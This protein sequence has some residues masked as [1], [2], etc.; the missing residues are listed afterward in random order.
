MN[1]DCGA[2]GVSIYE[3]EAGIGLELCESDEALAASVDNDET[4]A[5]EETW[6]QC[7]DVHLYQARITQ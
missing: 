1:E 7:F 6:R 5:E 3:S 2:A 4:E